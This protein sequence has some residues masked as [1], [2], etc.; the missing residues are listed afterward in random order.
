MSFCNNRSS[1]LSTEDMCRISVETDNNLQT[2][3]GP[4]QDLWSGLFQDSFHQTVPIRFGG[5]V[6]AGCFV[7]AAQ[8]SCA[9]LHCSPT[10][11]SK[12]AEVNSE[13]NKFLMFVLQG[14]NSEENIATV[15]CHEFQ[16]SMKCL[17]QCLCLMPCSL[18]VPGC[19][20]QSGHCAQRA[21]PL[22]ENRKLPFPSIASKDYHFS[23]YGK[24]FHLSLVSFVKAKHP[25]QLSN[26]RG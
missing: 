24:P 10:A 12:A 20:F 14:R 18:Q 3:R 25:E 8:A 1:A 15:P 6:A 17:A 19:S 26:S 9:V 5:F 21:R 11:K 16:G 2:L 13:E 23:F 7:K 22:A 4:R